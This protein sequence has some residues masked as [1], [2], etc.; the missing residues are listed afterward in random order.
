MLKGGCYCGAVRYEAAGTPFNET[1]CHCTICRGTTGA[2]F[3]A[4]FSV[5]REDFRFVAGTPTRF[6]STEKAFR[7]FCGHCGTQLTFESRDTP[8][9]IDISTASLDHP[10]AV[11][12]R[13]HIWTRS[14]LSWIRLADGLPEHRTI[15][16]GLSKDI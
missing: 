14:R 15:H 4:W 1:S 16:G 6:A 3:V 12:P 10:E 9:E 2:P 7:S 11:P 8:S 13:E 5:R